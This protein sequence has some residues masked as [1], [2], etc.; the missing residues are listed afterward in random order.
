MRDLESNIVKFI[1]ENLK[2]QYDSIINKNLN[3][4]FDDRDLLE[5]DRKI[6]MEIPPLTMI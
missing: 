1:I 5:H 4:D 3:V 2:T 6:I